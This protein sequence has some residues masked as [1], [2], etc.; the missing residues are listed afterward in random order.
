MSPQSKDFA[1]LQAENAYLRDE[2]ADLRRQLYSYR[3][4]YGNPSTPADGNKDGSGAQGNGQQQAGNAGAG[5]SNG[6]QSWEV[7]P[8]QGFVYG[9]AGGMSPRR[10]GVSEYFQEEGL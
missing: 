8:D 4:N 7:K 9:Q 3:M 10:S 5:G 1:Q 6:P 2:N